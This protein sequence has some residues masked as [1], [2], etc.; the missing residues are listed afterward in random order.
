[1]P[2]DLV[3]ILTIGILLIYGLLC[4]LIPGE[5]RKAYLRPNFNPSERYMRGYGIVSIALALFLFIVWA[6]TVP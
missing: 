6:K 4:L 3:I 5:T 2:K 1:M